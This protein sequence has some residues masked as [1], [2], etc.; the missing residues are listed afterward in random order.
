MKQVVYKITDAGKRDLL[1]ELANELSIECVDELLEMFAKIDLI[2]NSYPVAVVE[3]K[4]HRSGER[5]FV[6]GDD[7]LVN[8]YVLEHEE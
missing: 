1:T 5:K 7:N 8:R 6:L 3:S 4:H 2:D